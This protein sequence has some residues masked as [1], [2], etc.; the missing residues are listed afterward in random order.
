LDKWYSREDRVQPFFKFE[1][2]EHLSYVQG[3]TRILARKY[4]E[5][6]PK[7]RMTNDKIERIV[8]ASRLHD[9]GKLAM[10][11]WILLKDGRL[12]EGEFDLFKAHTVKGCEMVHLLGQTPDEEFNRICHNIVLYHHE[13][14]DGTGYPYGLKKDKIPME[15]QI[16]GLADMY[17][18]L[19]HGKGERK[20][21]TKE[22]AF[23]MLMR[24]DFGQISPKLRECF[25][26]VKEDMEAFSIMTE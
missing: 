15:A 20:R 3:Y 7:S 26:M 11:E 22:E 18:V 17:D 5:L 14:Y 1:T 21:F 4:A 6:Y 12:S 16:V 24:D 8:K 13:K 19:V 25:A 23:Q 10:P 9:V 2:E